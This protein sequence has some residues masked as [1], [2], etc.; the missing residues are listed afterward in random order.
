MSATT[1]LSP[2]YLVNIGVFA[3][4]YFLV[5]FASGMVGFFGPG[6]MFV[7]FLLGVLINGTVIMLHLARTP[8]V[9]ALALL[10]LIVGLGFVLTGHVWYGALVSTLL[11]LVGD[12]I[13]R[14]G[15]YRSRGRNVLA[16][17]VFTLWYATPLLPIIYQADAYFA[18]VAVQMNNQE[19]A[20]AMRRIFQ[21]WVIGVWAVVAFGFALCSGWLGTKVVERHFARAGI[22]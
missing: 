17:A 9:G 14:S 20:D 2:K 5:A 3:A 18:N 13:V 19:Y 11:G 8:T 15:D 22:V 12:L 1:S 4:I 21:P 6:F 16:Y 10:G 7:G